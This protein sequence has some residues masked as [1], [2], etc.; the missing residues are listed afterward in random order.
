[1]PSYHL[2]LDPDLAEIPRLLD[3]VEACCGAAGVSGD[4]AGKLAL[5]LEE[6]AAN[7]INH[8]FADSPPP[9]HLAVIL[10]IDADRVA[11]EII[12]NGKAF[13]PTA[14]PEPDCTLPLDSRDPGGLGIH[15]I[16]KMVDRVDYRRVG[17][18]NHLHLEKA[19]N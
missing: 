1:M 2:T 12:D 3:W 16:R 14:I 7:V 13:D 4:F 17:D 6:A 18:K 15:L 10:T 8:A 9:Y 5:T 11:A 19:R